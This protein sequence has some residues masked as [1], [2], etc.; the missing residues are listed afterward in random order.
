MGRALAVWGVALSAYLLAIFHR[1]SLAV[2]GLAATDRFGITAAQLAVFT[3]LQLLVYA[4][5]Q[6][7]VGLLIDRFGPR[8]LILTGTVV[9]TLAQAAFAVVDSYPAAL[10]A[11]TFVGI[12]DA[13]TWVCVLRL[14]SRW[15]PPRR[16]PIVTQLSGTLGQ[17]GAIAAAVPMGLALSRLG[18]TEAY[19]LAAG[20]GLLVTVALVLVLGDAPDARNLRGHPMSLG[21]VR[22]SLT[23]SW[24]HPG[25]RL[26]FWMHFVTQ[27]SATTLSL[28]WGYPFFV[29]GE[30]RSEEV[31]GLLLTSIV[32]AFMWSGPL[33]GFLVSRHPWHRSSIVLSIV[34]AIVTVWTAVL[35]WPGDA[36]LWLL[37]L[38]TQVVGIGG[39]ASMIGFDLARTSNPADRLASATGIINQAGFAAS[40]VVVIAVG[41]VL[42]WRTP[43]DS[44][45]YTPEAFR[46]ALAA[47]YPLWALG[48]L[49]VWRYRRRTRAV[50]DRA[51]LTASARAEG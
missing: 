22:G 2:A 14:V 20:L 4:A 51:G 3:M 15:F 5:M 39:P 43:G 10:V 48:L 11:R 27:F 9:M 31:A 16:V 33:L 28:L 37:L 12:G 24:G 19:L 30:G 32:V 34:W 1:T 13:M 7:P 23:A 6:I 44:T 50:I 42:D 49:Q 35:L 41:L 21:L 40:L 26:G 36:P 46:W 38:L 45:A 47:Q 8:S 29:R 25:T 18:W 17:L